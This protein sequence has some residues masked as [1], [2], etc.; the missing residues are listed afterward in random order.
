MRCPLPHRLVFPPVPLQNPI[1]DYRPNF[2]KR[3]TTAHPKTPSTSKDDSS[4]DQIDDLPENCPNPLRCTRVPHLSGHSAYATVS[5]VT[6]VSW[7]REAVEVLGTKGFDDSL[8]VNLSSL[9]RQ[10]SSTFAGNQWGRHSHSN[11]KR[12]RSCP[13]SAWIEI[14]G[15]ST[16]DDADPCACSFPPE[17][18]LKKW[19]SNVS[20]TCR[21]QSSF[22]WILLPDTTRWHWERNEW[23]NDIR[24]SGHVTSL[25][26]KRILAPSFVRSMIRQTYLWRSHCAFGEAF[27]AKGVSEVTRVPCLVVSKRD[28]LIVWPIDEVEKVGYLV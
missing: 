10:C 20:V 5:M 18:E 27:R 9:L 21:S 26:S 28:L 17:E 3:S 11:G 15:P 19:R 24:T 23:A 6:S 13:S 16:D 8:T 22:D 4:L 1:S 2:H 25:N 12:S 7:R 14:E